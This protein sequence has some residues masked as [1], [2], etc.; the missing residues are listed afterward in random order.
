MV[1]VE[2][3]QKTQATE[4]SNWADKIEVSEKASTTTD[5]AAEYFIIFFYFIWLKY[6]YVIFNG[7]FFKKLYPRQR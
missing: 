2:G 4:N 1:V 7:H 3:N 6:F 5:S